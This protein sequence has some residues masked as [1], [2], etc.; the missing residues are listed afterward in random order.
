M[1][2][3]LLEAPA[4][5]SEISHHKVCDGLTCIVR[6]LKREQMSSGSQLY[7]V[8]TYTYLSSPVLHTFQGDTHWATRASCNVPHSLSTK[9]T[10]FLCGTAISC[11]SSFLQSP[12]SSNIQT[13]HKLLAL[14]DEAS[15]KLVPPFPPC[16]Y[17]FFTSLEK[18]QD[19]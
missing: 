8:V 13:K 3:G 16:S 11:L 1:T 15:A 4:S 19:V 10:H 2:V 5:S 12:F 18:N 14:L 9:W 17:P 7:L 6:A